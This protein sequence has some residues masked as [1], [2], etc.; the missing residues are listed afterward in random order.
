MA[1]PGHLAETATRGAAAL[2]AGFVPSFALAL[3]LLVGCTGQIESGGAGWNDGSATGPDSSPASHAD[4]AG[5][6]TTDAPVDSVADAGTDAASVAD[7]DL[8][9]LLFAQDFDDSPLGIYNRESLDADWRSPPWDNGIDEG[10]LAIVEGSEAFSGRSLRVLYPEGGVGPGEGGAQW[11]LELGSS[12]DE[13]FLS[14]RVR[15]GDG[16]DFVRGGKLPGLV[17][18]AANTGGDPPDGTDGFSARMMWRVDGAVVQYLYHPDQP[19]TYGEDL[20]WEIGGE[21][22]FNPGQWHQVEHR[23]VMNT[24]GEHDG[25]VEGWFDGVLAL[26]REEIRFRDVDSFS[27]DALYFS[28]FFGGSDETWAATSDEYVYFDDFVIS[29]QP[30]AH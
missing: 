10:R 26:R 25:L 5:D 17:G 23:I 18:G 4:A 13:L 12:Y 9:A 1:E 22:F 15:F 3:S 2:G 29:T 20:S 7:A 28:T 19:G 24:P 6:S 27:I 8:S 21:R 16:F 30:I 14:Y 11:R